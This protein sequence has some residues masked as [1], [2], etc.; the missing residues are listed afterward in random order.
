MLH[1]LVWQAP[2]L[3][4]KLHV[5]RDLVNIEQILRGCQKYVLI[6]LNRWPIPRN[7]WLYIKNS[8]VNAWRY[9]K[10][11]VLFHNP[12]SPQQMPWFYGES[13]SGI[14]FVIPNS[15]AS[16]G[17][18]R[19][20]SIFLWGPPRLLARSTKTTTHRVEDR[21]GE[22]DTHATSTSFHLKA[23]SP[24]GVRNCNRRPRGT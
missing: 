15:E 3:D 10:D 9:P 1:L 14:I 4:H 7:T 16:K 24:Q 2:Q 6:P 22:P 19:D 11:F 17:G 23:A 12:K 8:F 21:G 13:S 5:G 20:L 18:R